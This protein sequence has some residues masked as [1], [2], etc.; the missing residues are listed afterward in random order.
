[1]LLPD[2]YLKDLSNDAEVY[3]A[4]ADLQHSPPSPPQTP[5]VSATQPTT[6]SRQQLA[7][8]FA[9]MLSNDT[10]ER[11]ASR[12]KTAALPANVIPDLIAWARSQKGDYRAA[13]GTAYV[14]AFMARKGPNASPEI[15]ALLSDQD[16]AFLQSLRSI[17]DATLQQYVAEIE[18]LLL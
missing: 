10:R 4:I 1:M 5:E 18:K 13:L 14:I 12:D 9:G 15:R 6:L 11:R 16:K 3:R 2:Y 8:L 17:H 7:E